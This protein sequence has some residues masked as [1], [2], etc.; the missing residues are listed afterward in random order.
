[1]KQ[2]RELCI[3][4]SLILL[5]AVTGCGKSQVVSTSSPDENTYNLKYISTKNICYHVK[6]GSDLIPI[7][8]HPG[9]DPDKVALLERL[10]P[11]I[12]FP[13]SDRIYLVGKLHREE[14]ILPRS[15]RHM[16]ERSYREFE[17]CHWFIKCPFREMEWSSIGG[18]NHRYITRDS[19]TRDDL[20]LGTSS[21]VELSLFQR[22]E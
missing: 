22:C 8:F 4:A 20:S 7:V 14:K 17:L 15:F 11:E 21:E 10:K 2:T 5:L 16:E 9:S 13:S 3:M 12:M 1:M 6:S 18:K 19:L